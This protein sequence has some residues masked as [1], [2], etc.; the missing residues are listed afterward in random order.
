MDL[1][2]E[3]AAYFAAGPVEDILGRHG[4]DFI[5]RLEVAA[6]TQSGMRIFVA[7]IWR[8][9]MSEAIWGRVLA[10]RGG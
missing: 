2:I 9:Q 5:D 1:T 3:Q 10:L 7:C 4:G 6:C 8:G